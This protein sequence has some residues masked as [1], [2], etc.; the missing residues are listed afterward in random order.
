MRRAL[1][2]A[3]GLFAVAASLI[4]AAGAAA[5]PQQV[6]RPH[7]AQRK[8]WASDFECT[9]APGYTATNTPTQQTCVTTAPNARC[10]ERSSSPVIVQ[11]CD[12]TQTGTYNTAYVNQ[13][14][15]SDSAPTSSSTQ[16]Q[17]GK[18][19]ASVKQMGLSNSAD[20]RQEADQALKGTAVTALTQKQ[21]SSQVVTVCQGGAPDCQTTPTAG[22]NDSEIRQQRMGLA[23][24][25]GPGVVQLQ[26]TDGGANCTG[27]FP[28]SPN[29]CA[30][31]V[32]N[33]TT[34]NDSDLQQQEHLSEHAPVDAS[35][36]QLQSQGGL[37]AHVLQP[38]SG[39]AQNTNNAHQH[40]TAE[41]NGALTQKQDP[42]MGCCSAQASH[43][44]KDDIHQV[45]V[46]Q[47]TS[48]S[49]Q[50]QLEI[51]GDCVSTGSCHIVSHGRINGSSKT[52][53]CS[54]QAGDGP[55][56]CTTTVFC[57]TGGGC[58]TVIPDSIAL[59]AL[60]FDTLDVQNA[61]NYVFPATLLGV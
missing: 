22:T 37:N 17:N 31:V 28:F 19:V 27:A 14:I 24:A 50:Q 2:A 35:Q 11:T 26:D 47:A 21:D 33:S 49:A 30:S 4:V 9:P 46:L 1:P 53:T 41:A 29:I 13:E 32:Q 61:I 48:P 44:S 51:E 12:I 16:T 39:D 42:G 40:L 7:V 25:A 59:L 18:Q 3:A 58:V 23:R 57:Q 6:S 20:V 60:G 55:A 38:T 45:G 10:V 5:T 52:D 34:K 36:S 8:A 15:D 54:A 56:A 43:K